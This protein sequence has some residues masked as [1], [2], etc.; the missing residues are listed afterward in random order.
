MN[1]REDP[2]AALAAAAGEQREQP[3]NPAQQEASSNDSA[4]ETSSQGA[5]ARRSRS[6]KSGRPTGG[7]NR[8]SSGPT[9][10]A[11]LMVKVSLVLGALL[12]IPALWAIGILL[13][14]PVPLAGRSH[15]DKVAYLML[16]CWPVAAI[17]IG[18]ALFFAKQHAREDAKG[19]G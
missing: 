14:L 5:P 7:R 18:G 4:T 6:R 9:P 13:G 15:A 12:L 10:A 2:A 16:L 11:R 1:E 17:L 8:R 19:K 3:G